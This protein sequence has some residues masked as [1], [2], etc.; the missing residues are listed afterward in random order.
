MPKQIIT[1]T[2]TSPLGELV[3]GATSRG[4][5]LLEFNLPDRLQHQNKSLKK[6]FGATPMV[7][8]SPFFEQLQREL[9]EYFSRR[10][11]TFGLPL[12]LC[13][14]TFQQKV[15]ANLL[16]I[17]YGA[18]ISYSDQAE[19]LG[20]PKAVRAVAGANKNNKIAIL[21]PCHRVIGK[22]GTMTGYG[23]EI[24]RKEYLISLEQTPNIVMP[25]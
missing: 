9:C 2:I 1:T 12:D 17:P 15:W 16:T 10:R 24:W 5:C 11:Q 22:D 20:T 18:T 25:A 21:T 7:G 3:A 19:S 13:G 23:G 6:H 4:I 14:T 8:E